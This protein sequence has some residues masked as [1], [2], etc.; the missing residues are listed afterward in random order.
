MAEQFDIDDLVRQLKSLV[1]ALNTM[2]KTGSAGGAAT[3]SNR[4]MDRLL[5]AIATMATSMDKGAKSSAKAIDEFVKNIDK[6]IDAQEETVRAQQRAQAE[7]DQAGKVAARQAY[8]AAEESRRRS[9]SAA[10]LAR[11]AADAEREARAEHVAG[12]QSGYQK[13]YGQLQD[14][15]YK[16]TNYAKRLAGLKDEEAKSTQGFSGAIDKMALNYGKGG[17]DM[18]AFYQAVNKAKRVLD[19]LSPL[20]KGIADMGKALYEGKQGA[21][22]NNSVIE[23]F[24]DTVEK[25][26]SGLGPLGFIIGKIVKLF[27]AFAVETNKMSDR[28]YKTYQDLS[29]V[30]VAASDGMM[31]LAESAQRLGLGLDE[32]GLQNFVKILSAASEDIAMMSGSAIQGRQ[33]FTELGSSIV[34]GDVG[35]QLMNMGMSVEAIN[36]GVAGF[37]KQQAAT[38]R[39]QGKTTQELATGAAAYLKEM[40]ALTKLTGIQ[41]QELE[42]QMEA[43]R[44]NER[45]AAHLE[46]LRAQ[47]RDKEADNL[48][49]NMAVMS[50]RFPQLAGGLKDIASG[51][52]TSEAAQKAQLAGMAGIPELMQKGLGSGFKEM[53][54]ITKQTTSSMRGLALTGNFEAVFGNYYEMLKARGMSEQDAL[55]EIEKIRADQKAQQEGAGDAA[56]AAQTNMRREQMNS[57]DALQDL[58]KAGIA[59]T[60]KAMEGLASVT[61]KVVTGLGG[62]VAGGMQGGGAGGLAAGGGAATGGGVS[63]AGTGGG[64]VVGAIGRFGARMAA[65]GIGTTG[66]MSEDDLR[67]RGLV[68]KKGDV[69]AKDGA[70]NPRLVDLAQKIQSDIP[71]FAYFSGFN[72]RFHQEKSPSSAHT[73]GLAADFTLSSRPTPEQGQAIVNQLKSMGFATAIDEYNAPSAKATAGHFHAAIQAATGGVFSGPRSGYNAMLHGTEAV[74]PLP[75]GKTIPVEMPN[76]DRSM[77][78]QVGM[79]G[80]QLIAL[81][82]LVRYMRDNNAINTKILQAANN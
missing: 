62:T 69:Q 48:E 30:G 1:E 25:V 37:I 80:A 16:E 33:A 74:V 73:Q 21:S 75:D 70:L 12:L 63:T 60:T 3:G 44:Q 64:G 57:R 17:G 39:A 6:A 76:L 61:S 32:S 8:E 9:M 24:G 71:G 59:P 20:G 49:Q 22:A 55:K 50:K 7:V 29:R 27:T 77:E 72:D 65:G 68:L 38:G 28:F 14:K 52:V 18:V 10:E 45:F 46:E 51:F 81:E 58:V 2:G 15:L 34:R 47:G 35:R 41:K 26:T 82:E 4:D 11:E 79:M 67:A 54:E 56:T 5:R 19:M 42:N 53:G 31:G 66:T 23:G 36:E 40:D 13:E 43:N 78:Q